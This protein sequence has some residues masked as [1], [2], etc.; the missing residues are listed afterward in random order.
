MPQAVVT[1]NI[2]QKYQINP[3]LYSHEHL[4]GEFNYNATLFAPPGTKVIVHIKPSIQNIWAP[5][6][7]NSWYTE[8]TKN[9]YICY[10]IYNLQTRDVIHAKSV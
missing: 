6:G 7:L 10:E 5:H 9:H 2:I 1:L 3:V 8:H 4:Y